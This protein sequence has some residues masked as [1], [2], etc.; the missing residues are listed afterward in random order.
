M[1]VLPTNST[2]CNL[3]QLQKLLMKHTENS[4]A[5]HT[6][7]GSVT[8]YTQNKTHS[9]Q[10]KMEMGA[11]PL[12]LPQLHSK[13]CNAVR[14][15]FCVEHGFNSVWSVHLVAGPL[16]SVNP[17]TVMGNGRTRQRMN[18]IMDSPVCCWIFTWTHT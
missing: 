3:S 7:R 13:N 1:S 6:A 5:L 15:A 18:I 16:L 17:E 9:V 8:H 4:T 14:G 2:Q 11:V 12:W 10:R